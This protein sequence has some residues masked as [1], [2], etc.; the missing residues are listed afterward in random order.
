MSDRHYHVRYLCFFS[1]NVPATLPSNII[2]ERATAQRE[3]RSTPKPIKSSCT[4]EI[5]IQLTPRV[6]LNRKLGPAH[7]RT[8]VCMIYL[9]G[10]VYHWIQLDRRHRTTRTQSS[11]ARTTATQRH[12]ISTGT[13]EYQLAHT[14]S[15]E[16][17]N[18]T[19][20][21][22]CFPFVRDVV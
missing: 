20:Q 13:R 16:L 5:R 7:T 9:C 6:Y 1:S 2:G 12:R 11:N 3:I 17:S 4:R 15:V 22:F 18:Q 19:G 14:K 10:N 21:T 8:I